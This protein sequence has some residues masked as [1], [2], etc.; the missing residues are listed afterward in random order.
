MR[1][2]RTNNEVV[3]FLINFFLL[4]LVGRV[5]IW[6][7]LGIFRFFGMPQPYIWFHSIPNIRHW[8][9]TVLLIIAVAISVVRILR[10]GKRR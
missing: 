10:K 1:L 8:T 4:Q 7:V 6:L 5:L 9:F 2:Y 3:I